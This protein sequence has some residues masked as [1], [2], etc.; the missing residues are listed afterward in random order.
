[1][2]FQYDTTTRDALADA[3]TS[4]L[5]SAALLRIYDGTPPASVG[6]ALSGNNLLGELVCG[7]PFAP[8][9][10]SGVLTANAI[11]QDSAAD[12]TGTAT[13]FRIL[14]SGATPK[15]Q[16]TAGTSGTDLVLNTASIVVGGPI[17]VSSLT[18]TIGGA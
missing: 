18:I 16:G 8:A 14:T 1:M 10:S 11:T 17:V 9:A 2:A 15:I 12:A 5:G 4:Q 3:I 7:S 6:A 13:F